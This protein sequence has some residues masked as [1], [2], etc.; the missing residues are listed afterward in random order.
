MK[1]IP[2]SEQAVIIRADYSD[3]AAWEAI[4]A[5]AQAVPEPF[6]FNMQLVEDQDFDGATAMELMNALGKNYPQSFFVIADRRTFAD[7]DH[8][9]LVVDLM[10]CRGREFRAIPS[11]I[12]SIDNNL[13]IANMDFGQFADA[14]DE[15]GIFRGFS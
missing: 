5:M 14:A 2:T 6:I 4:I 8:A 3:S 1:P 7:S 15:T 13:S 12:A 10:E 11:Q 9:L